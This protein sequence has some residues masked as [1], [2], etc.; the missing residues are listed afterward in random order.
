MSYLTLRIVDGDI[1]F[2]SNMTLQTTED[3]AQSFKV[4]LETQFESDFRNTNYGCRIQELMQNDYDDTEQLI[5]LYVTET[6]YQH[7][8]TDQIESIEVINYEDRKY[9][10][11]VTIKLKNLD[12][13]IE[14][15]SA[16]NV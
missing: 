2:D 14:V 16:I 5:S 11:N 8:L 6:I 15:T 9:R 3:I 4:L 12:E 10:V 7:P 1:V 13:T